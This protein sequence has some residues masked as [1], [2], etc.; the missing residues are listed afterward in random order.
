D[1][2][3]AA[4]NPLVA[5]TALF[6]A[7]DQLFASNPR[8]QSMYRTS[9]SFGVQLAHRWEVL[10]SQGWNIRA[11]RS[12]DVTQSKI[13]DAGAYIDVDNREILYDRFR[14]GWKGITGSGRTTPLKLA[15]I[16][17]A[18]EFGHF[19]GI[20]IPENPAVSRTLAARIIQSETNAIMSEL[21]FAG[22]IH[23]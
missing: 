6:G 11:L 8:I 7:T 17:L 16:S 5:R 23:V 15:G 14:A 18:H 10:E 2:S 13:A 21:G 9:G 1:R 3:L 20:P 4:L 22:E 19:D 12:S